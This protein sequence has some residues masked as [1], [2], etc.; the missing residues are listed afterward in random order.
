MFSRLVRA[1]TTTIDDAKARAVA[2][3]V[4]EQTF[5]YL[6]NSLKK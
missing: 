6:M 4:F 1:R 5:V 2:D 3:A